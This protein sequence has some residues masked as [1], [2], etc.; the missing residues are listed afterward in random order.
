MAE[1]LVGVKHMNHKIVVTSGY[2]NPLH[3]GHLE[4]FTLAKELGDYLI[5]IV[6]SDAQVKLKG[7]VPFMSQ[8]DRMA[9]VEALRVVDEVVLSIDTDG[10]VCKTLEMIYKERPFHIFAKGGD[11][12]SSNIPEAILC[13][14]LGI[15]IADGLGAKVRSSSGL[16]V[17]AVEKKIGAKTTKAKKVVPIRPAVRV[18]EPAHEEDYDDDADSPASDEQ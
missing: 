5:V 15:Q 10:S 8:E 9:I 16:I 2:F 4:C 11:R 6:N 12:M 18:V 14:K 17:D 3:V 1:L 13:D 7:S